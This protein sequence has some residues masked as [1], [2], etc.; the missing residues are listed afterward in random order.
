M[1]GNSNA[2]VRAI[3]IFNA[4]GKTYGLAKVGDGRVMSATPPKF[5]RDS[6]V[7]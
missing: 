5:G 6:Q 2:R 7:G 4:I 3:K 1:G